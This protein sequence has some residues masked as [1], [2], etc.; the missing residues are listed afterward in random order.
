MFL[1]PTKLSESTP[2]DILEAAAQGHVGLDRRVLRALVDRRAEAL[3]AV[4]EFCA[5]D[6]SEY[7][8]RY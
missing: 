3:P 2:S 6:R 5:K 1:D 7:P 8:D 4:T